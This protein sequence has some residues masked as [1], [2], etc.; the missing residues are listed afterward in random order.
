MSGVTA[1]KFKFGNTATSH[2][3]HGHTSHG[4][5]FLVKR[6]QPKLSPQYTPKAAQ[7]MAFFLS[8]PTRTVSTCPSSSMVYTKAS[9][10]SS[11]VPTFSGRHHSP[12]FPPICTGCPVVKRH[13]DRRCTVL[14]KPVGTGQRQIR[15]TLRYW[16]SILVAPVRTISP[17]RKSSMIFESSCPSFRMWNMQSFVKQVHL[18]PSELLLRARA[19][20]TGFGF[21]FGFLTRT[22]LMMFPST[23]LVS[24]SAV[25]VVISAPSM[26]NFKISR[27]P[28]SLSCRSIS[29]I[30]VSLVMTFSKRVS[31]ESKRTMTCTR[32]GSRC[33]GSLESGHSHFDGSKR[34]WDNASPMFCP[35]EASLPANHSRS[36]PPP[37]RIECMEQG[38]MT[39]MEESS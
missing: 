10:V 30:L 37:R 34:L 22:R 18:Q 32:S 7:R 38:H 1:A 16:S 33:S 29:A 13:P 5:V 2:F 36:P 20:T 9:R 3:L 12:F 31:P 14:A 15:V 17:S 11:T 8:F 25:A 35:T 39:C 24:P 23:T 26:K 6:F 4:L 21:G 28:W 19:V 27:S